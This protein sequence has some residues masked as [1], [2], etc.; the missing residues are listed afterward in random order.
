MSVDTRPHTGVTAAPPRSD[1]STAELIKQASGQLS[2]LV[3]QE[4]RLATAELAQKRRAAGKGASLMGAGGVLAFYGGAAL[5]GTVILALALV[6]PAWLAA[7][8]VGVFLL[9]VA[10]V[11]ALAGRASMRRAA[12]P[13]PGRAVDSLRQDVAELRERTHR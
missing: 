2:H 13:V 12:S 8:V 6:W 11:L 9:L 7:L 3:R 4:M 1:A 10:G 5:I